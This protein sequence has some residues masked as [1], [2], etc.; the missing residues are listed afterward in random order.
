MQDGR[1]WASEGERERERTSEQE[2]E[3]EKY[4]YIKQ[5]CTHSQASSFHTDRETLRSGTTA[6]SLTQKEE[7]R[8]EKNAS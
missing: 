5:S 8:K 3:L 2:S 6:G 7:S 4:V 1:G